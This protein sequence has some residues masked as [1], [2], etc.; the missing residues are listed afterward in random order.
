MREA[1]FYVTGY[2]SIYKSWAI[3]HV[4]TFQVWSLLAEEGPYYVKIPAG[5]D[6]AMIASEC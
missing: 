4:P 1:G 5:Y 3:E 2:V 6:P